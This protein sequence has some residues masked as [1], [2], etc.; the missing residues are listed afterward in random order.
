MSATSSDDIFIQ[1]MLATSSDVISNNN[2][3]SR[4][5]SDISS[6]VSEDFFINNDDVSV[7]SQASSNDV[8]SDNSN[9][10]SVQSDDVSIVPS[11]VISSVTDDVHDSSEIQRDDVSRGDSANDG[12]IN[13]TKSH[14]TKKRR[15]SLEHELDG[16]YWSPTP[17]SR[18]SRSSLPATSPKSV[19]SR[20]KPT[21]PTPTTPTKTTTLHTS[22]TTTTTTELASSP[23]SLPTTKKEKKN[24]KNVSPKR[25]FVEPEI[26]EKSE[27]SEKMEKMEVKSE[28]VNGGSVELDGSY[29]AGFDPNASRAKP[30]KELTVYEND[31]KFWDSRNQ[32]KPKKIEKVEE[33]DEQK[34][35][36][37]EKQRIKQEECIRIRDETDKRLREKEN[38]SKIGKEIFPGVFLGGRNVAKNIQFLHEKNIK[39]VVNVTKEVNNY[40]EDVGI[41]YR[42]IEVADSA[43]TDLLAHFDLITGVISDAL[44]NSK[45]LV[46]CQEG[47]SRSPTVVIAYAMKALGKPLREAFTT[48]ENLK[49]DININSGFQHQLIKYERALKG[50]C[51]FDFLATRK[52]KA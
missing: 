24:R 29:W 16:S 34:Q 31:L 17:K 9:T 41:T 35:R 22:S 5:A 14:S 6:S 45:V 7:S 39:F 8:F 27:K 25:L 18:V 42:R 4:S 3:V 11:D 51:S 38:N 30:R 1:S 40:H 37:I 32:R 50:E 49:P 43:N 15:K 44:K 47:K 48:V 23:S 28:I 12:V 21:F 19:P 20:K 2:D 10:S 13:T 36:R 52:S 26:S 46:H 33:T